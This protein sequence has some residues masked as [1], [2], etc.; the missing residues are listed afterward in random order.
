MFLC[1]FFISAGFMF[2]Q[3]TQLKFILTNAQKCSDER[4]Y[5]YFLYLGINNDHK[6]LK[7]QLYWLQTFRS[8][9]SSSGNIIGGPKMSR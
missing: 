9:T 2:S 4:I 8:I 1:H 6:G 7:I 5:V 3:Q